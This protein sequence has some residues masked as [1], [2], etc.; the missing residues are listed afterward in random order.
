MCG[1]DGTL[2]D[3]HCELHREACLRGEKDISCLVPSI[4]NVSIDGEGV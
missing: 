4:N 3:S 1:S 2:Y